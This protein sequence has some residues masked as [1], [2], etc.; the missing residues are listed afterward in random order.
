ML[1]PIAAGL[2]CLGCVVLGVTALR[3][4]DDAGKSKEVEVIVV[5]EKGKAAAEAEVV[6][7]PKDDLKRIEISIGDDGKAT[8]VADGEHN[9]VEVRTESRG[10]RRRNEDD[11]MGS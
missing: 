8:V 2:M 4:Q 1:R 9:N 7:E 10:G 6:I 3:G 5:D 11:G